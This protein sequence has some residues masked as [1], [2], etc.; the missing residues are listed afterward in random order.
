MVQSVKQSA[1]FGHRSNH[2]VRCPFLFPWRT[3]SAT[4][5]YQETQSSGR[6]GRISL[7]SLYISIN[8]RIAAT[9]SSP[10]LTPLQHGISSRSRLDVSS[11]GSDSG[12]SKPDGSIAED[13][14]PDSLTLNRSYLV[15]PLDWWDRKMIGIKLVGEVHD[16]VR[17]FD[18]YLY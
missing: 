13:R 11:S 1:T 12:S 10:A 4:F 16:L 9:I 2:R 18:L 14:K 15:C 3:C 6:D 8:D 7:V 5:V 17:S